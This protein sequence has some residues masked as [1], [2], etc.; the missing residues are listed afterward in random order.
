MT[1]QMIKYLKEEMNKVKSLEIINQEKMKN[2]R[3][4]E[5]NLAKLK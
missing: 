1:K 4:L 5:E 3:N 2:N